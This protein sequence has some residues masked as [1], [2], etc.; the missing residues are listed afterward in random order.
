MQADAPWRSLP[1]AVVDVETT[2][3]DPKVDRVIE[4]AIVHMLDGEVVDVF[5][6]LVD[7]E[8][9][10]P[11][12]VTKLT[13]IEPA[14]LVGAPRFADIAA[15][16]RRRLGDRIFVAYN[17]AFDRAFV[18]EELER[19]GH[20]APTM[21]PIDPLVFV[22][23]L[24]KNQGS[25]RLGAVAE[26]LGIPLE[27]AHRAQDDAVVAGK[28]LYAL[29]GELPVAL[30]DLRLLQDQ[31]EQLQKN[32]MATWRNQRGGAIDAPAGGGFSVDRGNALGPAYIY[33]DDTDPVR[34]MFVHLPDSGAKR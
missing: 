8:Q 16:V 6:S 28:I 31:W 26:R 27:N 24:H 3:L 10:L 22:R 9:E 20:D 32:E 18:L 29:A 33:G 14:Q 34:A 21:V 1:L 4:I 15:E 23:E 5:A 25:K 7:P 19:A 13:G 30:E 11:E 2:G 17:L 12:E